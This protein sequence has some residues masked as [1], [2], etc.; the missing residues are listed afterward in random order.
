MKTSE[1]DAVDIQQLIDEETTKRLHQ[2]QETG[3][4]FPKRVTKLDYV[5]MIAAVVVS[6]IMIILCMTGVIK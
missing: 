5:L 1:T 2:M 3:Y 6:E 4:E